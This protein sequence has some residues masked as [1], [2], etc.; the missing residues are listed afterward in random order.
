M[1]PLF[2]TA[3]SVV[4]A[5]G[6]GGGETLAS[7]RERRGGLRRADFAD[8]HDGYIGRVEAIEAHRL[9]SALAHYDCRNNRLADLA[10]AADDFAG[11]VARAKQTYGPA[12]IAVVV[13]TSTSGILSLEDAYR[14]RD[15]ATGRLPARFDYEHTHDLYSLARFVRD[16]LGLAGPA[17]SVSVACA[18]AA[19][20]FI[21]AHHLIEAGVSDAAVVG[22]ADT[23][24]RMT[25]HG[26][27]ALELISP[28][29]CR[30]AD[31]ARAGISIGE[32]AGFALLERRGEGPALLGYGASSDGYHMSAPHPEATGAIAAMRAALDRA[33]LQPDAIGYVNLHGTGTRQNDAME[34][35]A[36]TAVF[37]PEVAC[38]ST[39][40]WTGHALGS[41]GI[42]EAEITLLALGAG[43]LPGSLNLSRLDPALRA[44]VLVENRPSAVRRAVSN[45]FG[46]GGANV[47]LVL[48]EAA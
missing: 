11:A 5:I 23:L 36:V 39:K 28:E 29:P 42:L 37:G 9:A 7:L 3:G 19:R 41:S 35:L 40:G 4:S 27:A 14:A 32:A 1:R 20:A 30:P 17:L 18:S 31:A 10:L 6:L 24:C 38:S 48:G 44:N 13:G 26:F 43:F 8:V 22:G 46:F 15:P 47:S 21:D 45:S 34:D 16:A 25:L 33:G 12:R 2:I